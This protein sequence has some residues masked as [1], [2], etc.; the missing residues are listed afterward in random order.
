MDF[1]KNP[2]ENL[3]QIRRSVIDGEFRTSRYRRKIILEPKRREIFILPFS[4]DRI[5]HHAVM[6]VLIPIFD[7]MLIRDTHACRPGYGLHSASARVM[8][9]V[10]R[11]EYILQ[12]D[13]KKFYPSINHAKLYGIISRK[14][15]DKKLLAIIRD[16]IYSIGGEKN[17]PIGNF[18][19]QWFGNIYLSELDHFIKRELHCR[20]YL[21]Y[22]DDFCLF[23]KDK[24]QLRE[25]LGRIRDFLRD[26][27]LLELSYCEIFPVAS[28]LDFLG[29]RHFPE[30]I[31][32][33]KRTA[34]RLRRR[35]RNGPS[36]EQVASAWGWTKHANTHAF[37]NAVGFFKLRKRLW[38]IHRDRQKRLRDSNK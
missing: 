9:F 31:L 19:S 30:F 8:E 23:S 14:V 12:C 36:M 6:N 1:M 5:V 16:I 26:E 4:P 21:R 24:R 7:P 10:R 27:L 28:G 20:D 37:L 11:N 17:M 35:L 32:L 18:C 22:C 34:R 33:R 15:A 3:E 38:G 2:A 13:V 29:Y 25:W